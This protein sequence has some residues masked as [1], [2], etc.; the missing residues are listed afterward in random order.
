[1]R[2]LPVPEFCSSL[3][4]RVSEKETAARRRLTASP[5]AHEGVAGGVRI[6]VL[7][8]AIARPPEGYRHLAE[9]EDLYDAHPSE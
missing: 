7:V 6:F 8:C 1:M 5:L 4:I 9:R 3:R 2:R